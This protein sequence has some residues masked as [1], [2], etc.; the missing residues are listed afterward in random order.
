L[1][2]N[3][4]SKNTLDELIQNCNLVLFILATAL[5]INY[6]IDNY[7]ALNFAKTFICLSKTFVG[8]LIVCSTTLIIKCITDL[9]KG[10][11]D[12]LL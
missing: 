9:K 6:T 4:I 3:G 7:R 8:Y 2:I 10:V 11:N 1:E 12:E 5:V